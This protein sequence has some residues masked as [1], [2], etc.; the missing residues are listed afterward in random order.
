MK[1]I[2]SNVLAKTLT[3]K[4]Q[5]QIQDQDLG[6]QVSFCDFHIFFLDET[7]LKQGKHSLTTK[8][9]NPINGN[10][11]VSKPDNPVKK[12]GEKSGKQDENKEIKNS[13]TEDNHLEVCSYSFFLLKYRLEKMD[14]F[15]RK[16]RGVVK[17]VLSLS[18]RIFAPPLLFKPT[19]NQWLS[20]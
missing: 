2:V 7:S 10:L 4:S 8:I 16:H 13:A 1:S 6:I 14:F 5:N 12:D 3:K 20:L 15:Q 17:N 19:A 9:E 11:T 18:Y